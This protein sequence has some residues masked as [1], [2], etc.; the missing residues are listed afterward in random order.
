METGLSTSVEGLAKTIRA[1]HE[2]VA[3]ALERGAM[4]AK[5]AGERLI[6]AK[7]QVKH[8]DWLQFL[9]I[10]CE[11]SERTAGVYIQMGGDCAGVEAKRQGIAALVLRTPC[12]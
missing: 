1:D 3:G 5:N 12:G 9:A 4:H 2:A 6:Q 7:K 10:Y 11:I 8:G